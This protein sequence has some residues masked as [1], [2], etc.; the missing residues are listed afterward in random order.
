MN[1]RPSHQPWARR[2][3]Q[4]GAVSLIVALVLLLGGTI[5]AFF[6]NRGFIF[7]QR[8]S[9]NQYRATK[10]FELAEAGTEWA[11]GK[12][13]ERMPLSSAT[14][15]DCAPAASP[16]G[17]LGSF[18][19][20]YANPRLAS[21]ALCTAAGVGCLAPPN[22]GV[23]G[24]RISATGVAVCDCQTAAVADLGTSNPEQGRFGVRIRP[25]PDPTT[26]EIVSRGCTNGNDACDPNTDSTADATA[27]VRVLA[28]V[29]PGV[30]S[31]P[32]APLTSGSATVT[33]GSLDVIN[34][35]Q[36]SNG[37]T[38]HAG[39]TVQVGNGA[40]VYSLPG[41]PPRAS[42]LDGDPSLANLTNADEDAFFAKYFGQTLTSYR[43]QDPDVIHVG[44]SAP[45]AANR[46]TSAADCGQVVVA[47][48]GRVQYPRFYVDGDVS[49][50]GATL[51]AAA[52]PVTLVASGAMLLRGTITAHGLF[53]AATATAT[54]NWDF[55]GS[56]NATVYGAFISRG[57]FNKGAGN[58]RL[59]YP[60][61]PWW[62]NAAPP[63][64]RLARVPGSWRDK[65]TEF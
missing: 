35:N 34:N 43:S 45:I 42:I 55:N 41:T 59:I 11:L 65:L 29:V 48:A 10:A 38:I 8:T 15:S 31:G 6:A 4:S 44:P 27:I 47:N 17:A 49:F 5:I 52:S 64:G 28:K 56:G 60:Q 22:T 54:D 50:N 32:A 57:D 14:P 2:P 1:A 58:L 21:D 16:V 37:I 33:S 12:L 20:R 51:G 7:E 3:R 39:T 18:Y 53:Y 62:S 23:P 24:C 30:P 25:G 26:I 19:Q 46:C 63:V 9:A 40:N 13:N 61:S 36:A